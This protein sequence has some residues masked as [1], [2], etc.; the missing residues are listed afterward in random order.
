MPARFG[1]PVAFELTLE[2][3]FKSFARR[4]FL[5]LCYHPSVAG[6]AKGEAPRLARDFAPWFEHGPVHKS[7]VILAVATLIKVFLGFACESWRS[8]VVVVGFSTNVGSSTHI[9]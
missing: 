3:R 4:S 6:P 8:W 9:F 2:L 5:P 7:K 1:S